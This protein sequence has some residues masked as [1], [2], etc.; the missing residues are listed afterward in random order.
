MFF[1]RCPD[2][3]KRNNLYFSS[4]LVRDIIETNEDKVKII[5]TGVKA[6]SRCENRGSTCAFR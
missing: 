1:T 3:A 5:N 4:L 2:P 6:F